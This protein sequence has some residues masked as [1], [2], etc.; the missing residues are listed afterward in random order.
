MQKFLTQAEKVEAELQAVKFNFS[1]EVECNKER[2]QM[3]AV[4]MQSYINY[5]HTV[6]GKGNCSDFTHAAEE[7]C[8]RATSLLQSEILS[9]TIRAPDIVFVPADDGSFAV[10]KGS[11]KLVGSSTHGNSAGISCLVLISYRQ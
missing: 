3:T 9:T 6:R 2:L 8:T 4:A 5:S 7:L 10:A 11:L 1:K